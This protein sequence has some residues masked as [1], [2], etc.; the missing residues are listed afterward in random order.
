MISNYS[1]WKVRNNEMLK[2]LIR[3]FLIEMLKHDIKCSV[4][5]SCCKN[6]IRIVLVSKKICNFTIR[7]VHQVQVKTLL[8]FLFQEKVKNLCKKLN[9]LKY[10]IF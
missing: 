8:E 1:V 3:H 9:Y 2:T 7:V 10:R 5:K 4:R 6:H